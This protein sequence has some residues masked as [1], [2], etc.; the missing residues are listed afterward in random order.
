MK[1]ARETSREKR[2]LLPVFIGFE[3]E[4]AAREEVSGNLDARIAAYY[5]LASEGEGGRGAQVEERNLPPDT[6]IE[7]AGD[8]DERAVSEERLMEIVTQDR[9]TTGSRIRRGS[10]VRRLF[11]FIARAFR[12]QKIITETRWHAHDKEGD[13]QGESRAD[14]TAG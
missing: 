9:W 3:D 8:D 7:P 1:G 10:R 5:G 4:E 6:W 2:W 11:Q 14:G 12:R 13:K